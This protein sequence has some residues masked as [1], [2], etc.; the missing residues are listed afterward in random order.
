MLIFPR[1]GGGEGQGTYFKSFGGLGV[2][3]GLYASLLIGIF[4]FSHSLE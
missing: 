2:G 1:V 4:K 3:G